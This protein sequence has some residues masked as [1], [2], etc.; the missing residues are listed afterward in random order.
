MKQ[1]KGGLPDYLDA[2][3]LDADILDAA[4]LGSTNLGAS[5]SRRPK[6]HAPS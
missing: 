2:D 3:S 5:P 4:S 1:P 6:Y